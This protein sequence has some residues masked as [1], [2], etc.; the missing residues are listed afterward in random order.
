MHAHYDLD[1]KRKGTSATSETT[2][3]KR[4]GASY[5]ANDLRIAAAGSGERSVRSHQSTGQ[6][7]DRGDQVTG[8]AEANGVNLG[9]STG[10]LRG[11]SGTE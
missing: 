4:K 3:R 5:L 2:T 7:V 10:A 1:W 6:A 8:G 11:G 9:S